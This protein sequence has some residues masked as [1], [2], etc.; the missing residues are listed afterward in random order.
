MLRISLKLYKTNMLCCDPPLRHF[1]ILGVTF[2]HFYFSFELRVGINEASWK[3][4][5]NFKK[6]KGMKKE[7][8]NLLGMWCIETI[9][10]QK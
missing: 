8:T 10:D 2:C 3:K 6:K 9:L 4:E 1:V 5:I 7:M